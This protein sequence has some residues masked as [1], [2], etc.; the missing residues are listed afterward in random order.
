MKHLV[1]H[2]IFSLSLLRN[3]I[4]STFVPILLITLL[5]AH[6]YQKNYTKDMDTLVNTSMHSISANLDTYLQELDQASL[7]PYYN[8]S[9]S[10]TLRK[11]ISEDR[12][13]TTL[14]KVQMENS[15]GN[16]LTFSQYSRND[17]VSTIVVSG[18]QC[19]YS[20]TKLSS[21]SLDNTYDYSQA[22]WY[23]T[24]LDADGRAA[25]IPPHI[26]EYYR[27]AS[28]NPASEVISVTR[29][30]VNLRTRNPI[31][32]I[33]IDANMASFEKMFHDIEW[34]VPSVLVITNDSD[35]LVYTTGNPEK[36]ASATLSD[37]TASATYSGKKWRS[38]H[39]TD[40]SFGW[41][42]YVLLDQA[43]ISRNTIYIYFIAAIIYLIGLLVATLVY[44]FYSRR[45]IDTVNTINAM[46]EQI[47]N[48][49]LDAKPEFRT[50]NELQI[51]IDSVLYMKELLKQ[52]IER[53]YQLTIQ[54]KDFQFKALQ[55]QI[56]PHFLYN[57]LNGLIALNQIGKTEALNRSLYALTNMMRYTLDAST[58]STVEQEMKFLEDYC[59]LQKLRF[60][61]KLTYNIH[62]DN[63]AA[64]CTIPKLLL[65]P[66]VENAIIH[67]IEPQTKAC[68]VSIDLI[69]YHEDTLLITIED[70]GVGFD[71]ENSEKH[72]GIDNVR[73]RLLLLHP[74]NEMN[75]ETSPGEGTVI[76]LLLKTEVHSNE[77]LN[78]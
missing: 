51:L 44:Y 2:N 55:A 48:G 13:P 5:I 11:I 20:N 23:Q 37:R 72:I 43:A 61:E 76:T 34:H 54:Q 25:F 46:T 15:L 21:V 47:R 26:P 6:I 71:L 27:T 1:K 39:E 19:F 40:P 64:V 9:F 77:D 22:D 18:T 28:G 50:H 36:I 66:L 31:C 57:T 41:N 29:A 59:M 45:I 58:E 70:D 68:L 16:M 24:A 73:N 65:Q 42:I 38:Y 12:A 32:V 17:L 63:E 56:N 62:Y 60:Q 74:Q 30:I 8:E 78:C 52:K 69:L 14:E 49:N 3:Y 10:N 4:L 7:M 75:I 35:E 67:G 33:K 53:E